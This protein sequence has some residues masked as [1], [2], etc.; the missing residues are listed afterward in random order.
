MEEPQFQTVLD[1]GLKFR[2]ALD[3]GQSPTM[4]EG[5]SS[6]LRAL[7]HDRG[8]DTKVQAFSEMYRKRS[9]SCV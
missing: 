3:A 2:K 1:E 6:T 9:F 7:P 5:V 8:T 4:L